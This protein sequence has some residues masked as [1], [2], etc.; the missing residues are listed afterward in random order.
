M[1][2]SD[3]NVDSY[4]SYQEKVANR[5][6]IP[7]LY[8]LNASLNKPILDV[9]CGKGGFTISIASALEVSIIGIDRLE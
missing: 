1:R 9:G 4:I 8:K 7:M 6:L 5:H 2:N 3:S